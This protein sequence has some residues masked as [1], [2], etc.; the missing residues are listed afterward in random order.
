[1]EIIYR[2]HLEGDFQEKTIDLLL[3]EFRFNFGINY[4]YKSVYKAENSEKLENDEAKI[5]MNVLDSK[6]IEV[7]VIIYKL[8][9]K[10]LLSITSILS[11]ALG[12]TIR[13]SYYT[14]I[15]LISIEFPSQ[16]K[17]FVGPSM[18]I[19]KIRDFLNLNTRPLLSVPLAVPTEMPNESAKLANELV[20]N[21]V[22]II[23]DSPL[24]FYHK[25]DHLTSYIENFIMDAAKND[26]R[27]ICFI[28][29]NHNIQ[30]LNKIIIRLKKI[31]KELHW[32]IGIR[33]DPFIVGFSF[34]DVLT[35]NNIPV[36]CYSQL[37]RLIQ[38]STANIASPLLSNL[39]RYMG[40]DISR[41][42]HW[43]EY[44]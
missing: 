40:A 7:I 18:G 9:K 42:W 39:Y 37:N 34:I 6:R 38:T 32:P 13:A 23:V 11:L 28:N 22:N 21:G 20:K 33:I 36:L 4:Q 3:E 24:R 35:R 26:N 41:N 31:S 16:S 8:T 14:S 43:R 17:I 5:E 29:G 27:A 12:N 2:Y 15:K 25:L 19:S 1:M 44:F 10:N 30:L